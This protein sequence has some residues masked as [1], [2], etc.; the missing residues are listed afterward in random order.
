MKQVFFIVALVLAFIATFI[1]LTG[2]PGPDGTGRTRLFDIN[3]FAGSFFFYL[4]SIA[5]FVGS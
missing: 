4:L 1:A 5:W 2:G 3:F